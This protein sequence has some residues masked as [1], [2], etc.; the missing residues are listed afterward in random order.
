MAKTKISPKAKT[1]NIYTRALFDISSFN[2]AERTVDVVFATETTDVK[3]YDWNSDT[4]F[5]E[6]LVCSPEAVR[7][8]RLNSGAPLLDNHNQYSGVRSVLG[9]VEKATL[10][11]NEGRATVRF[12]SR[13]DVK[14]I[15]NDVKEGIL[16][17]ISVGY[18]VYKY[19]KQP[20]IEGETPVYRAIDWEP[21]EI[22]LA[23]VPADFKSGV[24]S[25]RSD[26]ETHEIEVIELPT[27][28]KNPK[29]NQ[30]TMEETPEEKTARLA[31]E[32]KTRNDI[33]AAERTRVSEI[34][35]SVRAAGLETTFAEQHV[36]EGTSADEVRKL[37][38]AEMGKKD[39]KTVSTSGN[40]TVQKDA[41]EKRI[42]GME[43]AI[44]TRANP[45][46]LLAEEKGS[47]FRGMS[48][49]D[50]ARECLEVVSISTR[51][52]SSREVASGA[53]NGVRGMH[54]TS[55][56]PIILG[57]TINRTLR[58]AYE[59]AP[60]TFEPFTRRT[61]AKD[62]RPMTRTQLGD[63]SAFKKVVEGGE[64]KYATM[65]EAKEAYGV[66][67][68]GEIIA[69]TWESIIND[70]LGAFSRIPQS[71]AEQ[72][73]QKQSDIIWAIITG[74]PAMSDAV[75]LFH[76]S[77]GNL[78]GTGTVI[79][80]ENLGIARK[81]IRKQKSIGGS[82]L[83]LTPEF[84]IVAPELE[85][86]A[87]QYT[88]TNFV[89]NEASKINNKANTTLQVIVEP[90]LS[91]IGSG[92]TWF[93]SSGPGR[94]DTIEYAFLEGEEELFTE[95]RRGFDVDGLET[96]VRMVFGAAPIDYR[97]LYK[98]AGA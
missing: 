98:N 42:I 38:I 43:R 81:M 74:N 35:E 91:E 88:S 20:V 76:A 28:N 92:K 80:V 49:L 37:V 69:L 24:R 78:T 57:N 46:I 73:V 94:V 79:N 13:E 8:D 7:M 34:N 26:V 67:K 68:Y 51:G 50:M 54:S 60:K 48:L 1:E 85:D 41:A 82:Y 75:A 84:L 40:V 14:P 5:I 12:S 25:E 11:S 2:E 30:R 61:T 66:E 33:L 16:R 71:I 6:Q 29:N 31:K 3:R 87:N 47:E 36:K 83:N 27:E 93:M 39:P 58:A 64:Y 90:R 9:V 63:I 23:V 52:M 45:T 4:M 53:L 56:F 70:D 10:K 97:G 95:Q 55:D 19:E 62:F 32:D 17:A 72:A 96:K 59:L 44:L 18:R 77:H 21:T 22:S 65:G 86:V 15:M 89:A